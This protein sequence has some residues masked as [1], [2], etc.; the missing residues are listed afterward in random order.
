M[1]GSA[2]ISGSDEV[3]VNIG[4]SL[5]VLVVHIGGSQLVHSWFTVGSV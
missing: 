5:S 2:K 3:L 4:G 1:G